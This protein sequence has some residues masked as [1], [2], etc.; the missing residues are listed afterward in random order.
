[1]V[2]SIILVF[3]VVTH[4]SQIVGTPQQ[5]R[6]INFGNFK[7]DW[8]KRLMAEK[9]KSFFV[10]D[11]ELD[12]PFMCVAEPRCFS[13]NIATY[14]DSGGLRLCEVLATDK[15]RAKNMLQTNVTFHHYS[16]LVSRIKFFLYFSLFLSPVVTL[17]SNTCY[18]DPIS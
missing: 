6:Q 4:L 13:F 3:V 12:C 15:Y 7:P 5:S 17:L 9:I 14:P 18:N 1:M 8:G 10:N 11:I 2:P 16:P